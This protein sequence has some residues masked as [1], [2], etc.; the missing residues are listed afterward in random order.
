MEN[1]RVG[2]RVVRGRDWDIQGYGNRD[3]G[4]GRDGTIVGFV[5]LSDGISEGHTTCVPGCCDVNWDYGDQQSTH[6]IG[7]TRTLIITHTEL[8]LQY[9]RIPSPNSNPDPS[10][11]NLPGSCNA[12]VVLVHQDRRAITRSLCHT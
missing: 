1:V 12:W 4:P 6:R 8:V 9:S 3:G 5:R 10:R 2:A 11:T 7:R